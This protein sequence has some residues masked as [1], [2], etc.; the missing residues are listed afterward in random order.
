MFEGDSFNMVTY[1]LYLQS[2]DPT[3]KKTTII[4]E[5][6][7]NHFNGQFTGQ[8]SYDSFKAFKIKL[9][10]SSEIEKYASVAFSSDSLGKNIICNKYKKDF[11]SEEEIFSNQIY[12]HY[13]FRQPK[14]IAFGEQASSKLGLNKTD[15]QTEEPTIV[16]DMHDKI[17]DIQSVDNYSVFL[18]E[19]GKLWKA[20]NKNT[21]GGQDNSFRSVDI[22]KI[23]NDDKD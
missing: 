4:A 15:G 13:P 7:H 12:V 2:L 9:Q 16:E 3:S 19:N 20:G 5:S 17:V 14:I 22:N 6:N 21:M 11:N 18:D 23:A 1:N 10:E 8:L